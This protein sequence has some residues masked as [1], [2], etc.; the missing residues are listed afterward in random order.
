MIYIFINS[1]EL[2][3]EEEGVNFYQLN[4]LTLQTQRLRIIKNQL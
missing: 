1:C 4:R 2:R 3:F